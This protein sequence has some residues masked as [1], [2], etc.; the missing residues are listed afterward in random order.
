MLRNRL[1]VFF[2]FLLLIVGLYYGYQSSQV[3]IINE[4]ST[5]TPQ[6]FDVTDNLELGTIGNDVK[7]LQKYLNNNSFQL[8]EDEFYSKS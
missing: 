5:A 3:Q 8:A 6:L 2:I 1:I 7:E 4:L